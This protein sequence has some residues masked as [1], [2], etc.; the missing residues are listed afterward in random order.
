[1]KVVLFLEIYFLFSNLNTQRSG[2]LKYFTVSERNCVRKRK[3]QPEKGEER[4]MFEK[5]LN[6]DSF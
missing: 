2:K 1:M 5:N 3:I 4:K 6:F